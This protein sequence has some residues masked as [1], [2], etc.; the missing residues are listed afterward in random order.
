[1][2]ISA[3]LVGDDPT[4]GT[5]DA[6]LIANGVQSTNDDR[7]SAKLNLVP[8]PSLDFDREFLLLKKSITEANTH[9]RQ[10][11]RLSATP[12]TTD[13]LRT[14]LT[15]GTTCLHYCGHGHPDYIPVENGRGGVHALTHS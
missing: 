9:N 2:L 14:L 13:S 10:A 1:M 8:L 3:P 7:D 11:I 12:A 15:L 6:R 5:V 4:N